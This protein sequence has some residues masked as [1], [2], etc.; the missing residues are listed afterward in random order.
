MNESAPTMVPEL[1]R[2]QLEDFAHWI[3]PNPD[4]PREFVF[5]LA[6]KDFG[7]RRLRRA[8]PF[9][10]AGARLPLNALGRIASLYVEGLQRIERG[11]NPVL[12]A[13]NLARKLLEDPEIPKFDAGN[14]PA[15][16]TMQ[17]MAKIWRP[18][19]KYR[20]DEAKKVYL[21]LRHWAQTAP[22]SYTLTGARAVTLITNFITDPFVAAD[23]M[24]QVVLRLQDTEKYARYE[25][26]TIKTKRFLPKELRDI[27]G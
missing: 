5:D 26:L 10:E 8:L 3:T 24:R 4:F 15:R 12:G 1:Q 13:S 18:L 21:T 19:R 23:L 9:I 22:E 27:R 6:I 14:K 16:N 20:G 2:V 7:E 17:T 11:Y 25:P